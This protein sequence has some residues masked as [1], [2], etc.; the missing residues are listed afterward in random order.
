MTFYIG[1]SETNGLLDEVTKFHC[2]CFSPLNE[3]IFHVFCDY[4]QI[5]KDLRR[6]FEDQGIKF[7]PTE[8]YLKLLN[9]PKTTGICIHNIFGY[10]LPV[11]KKLSRIEYD[12]K[13][14]NG[15]SIEI[16]DSLVLSQY[17]KPDRKPPKGCKGAHGL[18]SWGVRLGICKPKIEDWSNQPLHIYVNRVIEDVKINKATYFTLQK[19]IDNVAIPNGS[20]LGNWYIPLKMSHKVRYLMQKQEETGICFDIEKAKDLVSNI[21]KEMHEIEDEVEKELGE[22][23]LP[24]NLQPKFPSSC[25]KKAFDYEKPY[26]KTGGLKKQ[27]TDYLIKIGIVEEE[28]E[29]YIKT[30]YIQEEID[31]VQINKNNIEKCIPKHHD[32]LTTNAINYCKKLGIEDPNAMINEI[33]RVLKGGKPKKLVEKLRLK[34]KKDVKGY[35]IKEGGWEPTI[36]KGRSIVTNQKKERLSKEEIEN[37]LDT[38]LKEF[39]ESPYWPFI[40]ESLGYK[41]DSNIDITS[42]SFRDKC[43]KNGRNLRSSPQYKDVRGVLCPNFEK[44][45]GSTSKK[46]IK[47]LALQNRL[48]T[49]CSDNETGWLFH[50]RLKIDSRLPAKSSG[51]TPTFRQTHSIVCNIPKPSDSVVLGKEI[52]GLFIPKKGYY[53]IGCDA[54]GIQQRCGAHYA[55]YFDNGEY[56]KEII[57]GDTHQKNADAYTDAAGHEITRS[58]GKNLTYAI[59][60]GATGKKIANMASVDEKVGFR[61]VDSFWSVNSGIAKAKEAMEK[62]WNATG[63]K[64][65]QG[66]DGRKVF[67]RSKHS[68]FNFA[69]QSAEAILMDWA[70]CWMD[71][72]IQEENIDFHRT[73]FIHDEYGGEHSKDEVKEYWFDEEPIQLRDGVLYSRPEEIDGKWRQHYSRAGE[74][75]ALAIEN[76]GK[77]YKMNLPFPGEYMCSLE[78]WA[79]TH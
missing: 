44:V 52:R 33:F 10:D 31:G 32:L 72:M 26:K 66:L 68:I 15:R 22:R 34:H 4:N 19:E 14:I 17:L 59:L 39:Y 43:I 57:D 70:G 13:S 64:Y 77:Y 50:R 18:E 29:N 27:T 25:F 35:L 60:F 2:I 38:Y 20:K 24:T 1:D 67:V 53:Q 61:L 42:K 9:S 58:Q 28:Q 46:I 6:N 55:A 30:M 36:W 56:A 16:V 37:K 65:I 3:D 11:F 5:N 78:S 49:I 63:K 79:C 73:L 69:C 51:I 76:A 45:T 40:L 7:Y 47:W 71:M 12:H 8:W 48:N 21:K 23:E 62:Y 54:C 75:I 41:K 74:I